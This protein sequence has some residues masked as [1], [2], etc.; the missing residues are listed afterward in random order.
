MTHS[1]KTQETL[2]MAIDVVINGLRDTLTHLSTPD[3]WF[4]VSIEPSFLLS[5]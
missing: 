5:L 4:K 1:E 2:E 3:V